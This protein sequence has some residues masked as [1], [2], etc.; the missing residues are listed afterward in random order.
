MPI[1]LTANPYHNPL[2]NSADDV[3]DALTD[4]VCAAYPPERTAAI[5]RRTTDSWYNRAKD[6]ISY[7]VISTA[8][9]EDPKI[10]PDATPLQT[11]MI[12]QLKLM[13][14]NAGIDDEY[15]PAFSS[16][17][18]QVTIPSMFGCVKECISNSD[19]VRPIIKSPSDV[20]SLPP[21]EVREGYVCADFINRM[22]YKYERCGRR[23][24]VFMT[25]VQGPFSCA[26][27]MWGIEDF[28]LDMGDYETE[29]HHLLSLC[30]D[31]II[32][33][34]DAMYDALDGDMIPIHCHPVMWV[35]LDAGVAV[36]DDFFA[37]V[38]AHTVRDFSL[39]YLERIG[40][41]SF[42]GKNKSRCGAYDSRTRSLGGRAEPACAGDNPAEV[43]A[44]NGGRAAAGG[45][46]GFLVHTCGN[47][48][49]LAPLMNTAKYIRGV[50]FSNSETDVLRYASENRP[51][52]AMIVHRGGLSIGGLPILDTEGVIAHCRD[53]ARTYG[54]GII[55]LP[56]YTGEP[57]TAENIRKWEAAA[58]L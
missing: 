26:A 29:A 18:E 20:Y 5:R 7:V 42:M 33:Y 13:L 47:M 24:P 11:E 41:H 55:A 25:D 4:A 8:A 14:H 58:R 31:A 28:L 46:S 32:K 51:D 30:T 27:Q 19:H 23:I 37:V 40:A 35:P 54:S 22:S 43:I 57:V 12:W 1:P 53:A 39:P 3:I 17:L 45:D 36:S 10:P 50:N 34:F 52:I 9:P 16:G 56:M 2:R 6:R 38:G 49:H 15:Y 44:G 48:N 21:A